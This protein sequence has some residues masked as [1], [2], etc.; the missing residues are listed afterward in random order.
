MD[1]INKRLIRGADVLAKC[2]C[3]VRPSQASQRR[4]PSPIARDFATS[5]AI[6]TLLQLTK[7]TLNIVFCCFE[8]IALCRSKRRQK[9][10]P[11]LQGI[12]YVVMR[13]PSQN[14]FQPTLLFAYPKVFTKETLFSYL[15]HQ[16]L[17]QYYN[18]LYITWI[19]I[20]FLYSFNWALLY[21]SYL[22]TSSLGLRSANE[23]RSHRLTKTFV[24]RFAEISQQLLTSCTLK[25]SRHLM[26]SPNN[27]KGFC[28]EGAGSTAIS[29]SEYLE[30]LTWPTGCPCHSMLR[31]SFP[32]TWSCRPVY[33]P[34]LSKGIY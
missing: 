17:K 2:H 1:E 19:T 5:T 12:I 28:C 21:M 24:E 4:N 32:T 22:P 13:S 8:L 25:N 11:F 7:H 20:C 30:A 33:P 10:N 15:L 29:S 23:S 31:A 26:T 14:S 34:F 16:T 18:M 6:T 27:C 9:T 3:L